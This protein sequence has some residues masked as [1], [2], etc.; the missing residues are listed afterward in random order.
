MLRDHGLAVF[1]GSDESSNSISSTTAMGTA[2]SRWSISSGIGFP[3]PIA[4]SSL[5]DVLEHLL[6]HHDLGQLKRDATTPSEFR[7]PRHDR[8]LLDQTVACELH[9]TPPN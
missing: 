2:I 6:R 9:P 5:E 1:P 8:H 7:A 3:A 4:A